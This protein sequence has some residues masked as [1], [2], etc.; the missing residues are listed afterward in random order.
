MMKYC[1]LIMAVCTIFASCKE[2]PQR[3]ATKKIMADSS[4]YTTA[5]WPDSVQNFGNIKNGDKIKI[6]F[7]CIN[8]GSKPLIIDTARPSCGCTVADYTKKP[9]APGE[10][11]IITAS[12]DSKRFSG[13]VTKSII[14]VANTKNGTQHYLY[15]NGN[16]MGN[17]ENDKIMVPHEKN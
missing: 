3:E 12:F 4:S 10:E 7:R 9:I 16:I 13:S 5:K 6:N 2:N 17:S 8:T 14:V 11:G 1:F 15:F